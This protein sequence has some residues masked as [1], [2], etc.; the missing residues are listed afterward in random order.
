MNLGQDKET[1]LYRKYLL[2]TM[3]GMAFNAI[4]I[5][6]D[7]LMIGKGIGETALVALNLLLPVF[8]VYFGVGYLFGIG[9]S[10]LLS[11]AKGNGNKKEQ[12]RIFTTTVTAALLVGIVGSA[13]PF[14]LQGRIYRLMGVSR[15]VLSY[16]KAY[17]SIFFAFGWVLVMQPVILAFVRN[18]EAPKRAMA[19]TVAGSSLNVIL[20][21]IFI[22]K[23]NLGMSGAIAATIIGNG[24][25]LCIGLSHLFSG[26]NHLH[27]SWR[28]LRPERI[29]K[30]MKNGAAPCLNEV[31]WGIVVF[32]FNQ[33]IIRYYGG[34]Y[35]LVIYSIITNT[36]IVT[37]SFLNGAGDAMQPMVSYNLG[38]GKPRRIKRF[39]QI[40][41]CTI[42]GMAVAMYGLIFFGTNRLIHLFVEPSAV[43]VTEGTPAIRIYFLSILFAMVNIYSSIFFQAVVRP[44]YALTISLLRG[45]LLSALFVLVAPAF[46]GK[47]SIW[48]IMT[49]VEV[50]TM[51]VTLWVYARLGKSR[52]SAMEKRQKC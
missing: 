31:A 9:G 40:G 22:Y 15:E 12:M 45:F 47:E 7:T 1:V 29:P 49:A 16:A 36:L 2:P 19:G 33:Q 34:G 23:W 25:N 13:V 8:S 35:A 46:F 6:T 10:V 20:D 32:L 51:A 44:K 42:A 38:A 37:N 27:F 17:G 39:F 3:L 26:K 14:L 50:C 18:D 24:I 48:W 52:E 4:Y 30:I 5:I 43:V 41:F 28:A 21:Y 11:V